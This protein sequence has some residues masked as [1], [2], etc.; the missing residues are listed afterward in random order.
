MTI[1][2][3]DAVDEVDPET[4]SDLVEMLETLLRESLHLIKIFCDKSG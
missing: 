2:V 3:L 1:I 4:R